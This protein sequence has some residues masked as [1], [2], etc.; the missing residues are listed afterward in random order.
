MRTSSTTK[1]SVALV[2]LGLL[3]ACS[4]DSPTTPKATIAATN[5]TPLAAFNE[6]TETGMYLVKHAPG[7]VSTL[8]SSVQTL[9]GTVKR[10]IRDIGLLYVD[11]LSAQGAASLAAQSGVTV[12]KDRLVQFV[13]NPNSV[14][15]DFVSATAA[16][17][18]QGTD[19]SGA[20]FFSA[21]QWN[22][23]I[24]N[25][26]KA[27]VPSNG[28][29]GETVC[30]LDTGVDPGHLDLNGAVNPAK[31]ATAI[32]VPRFPSDATPLDFHFHGTYV[33]ALARSNGI[34]IASVAPNATLCSIKVLSEDGNGTFG[35][36]LFGIFAAARF[37]GADVINMSLSGFIS[38]TNPA[39]EP[40]LNL[41][42]DVIDV[43]RNQGALVVAA[44]G[45]DGLNMDEVR[46]TFG[47]I[48]IPAMMPGVI[49]V[50]ATGPFQQR[51]F[52]VLAGYSNF[53]GNG[54]LDF[55]APGG[56]AGRPGFVLADLVL[57][58]CSRFAFAGACAAGNRYVFANGTSA[59]APHVSGAGAL[60]ESNVGSLPI[61]V[62]EHCVVNTA[63]PLVPAW[64]LGK[65][66]LD[67]LAA[68]KCVK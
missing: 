36:V 34:G 53:G 66:R 56:N 55:V 3:N 24:I 29:S 33:S 64:K 43:A 9:G 38:I 35:D 57:S 2:A 7:T 11:G 63:K 20:Q 28:G 40:L 37:F 26:D 39:N 50:G 60:V 58:A 48:T 17:V 19:Q 62:L 18:G 13:P 31:L 54:G 22:M 27:W 42:Q 61:A 1:V 25:A 5:A 30:V 41:L 47:I 21:F 6:G 8:R 51:D 68:H 4:T 59:A 32:L 49:S 23:R 16:A 46:Q 45:N 14:R 12:A 10:E 65:G 44:A 67:V 52:D 15:R